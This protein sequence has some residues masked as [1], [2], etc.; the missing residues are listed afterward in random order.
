MVSR[1]SAKQAFII[2]IVTQIVT[3]QCTASIAP[4]TAA[5]LTELDYCNSKPF[6]LSNDVLVNDVLP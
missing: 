2:P 5:F 4:S 6:C 1:L 3:T